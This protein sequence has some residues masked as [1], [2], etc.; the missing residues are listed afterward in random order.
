[1]SVSSSIRYELT[2]PARATSTSRFEFDEFRDPITS[3][4]STTSSRSLT[5]HCRLDV[6]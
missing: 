1:M 2:P 6:A 4:S 5:A 3:S